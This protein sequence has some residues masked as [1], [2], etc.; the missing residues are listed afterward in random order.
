MIYQLIVI[1][2]MKNLKI[3]LGLW[4]RCRK[5]RLRIFRVIRIRIDNIKVGRL[6][7]LLLGALS[8]EFLF[9]LTGN[10]K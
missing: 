8:S 3:S 4:Q 7:Q 10:L 6:I 1:E 9:F 2:K 5:R